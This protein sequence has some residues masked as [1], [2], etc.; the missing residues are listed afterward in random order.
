MNRKDR[1]RQ[2]SLTRHSGN[3]RSKKEEDIDQTRDAV[4]ETAKS[5]SAENQSTGKQQSRSLF[6]YTTGEGLIG[7]LSSQS[8]HATHAH[9]LNDLSEGRLILEILRPVLESELAEVTPTL[10]RLGLMR[11]DFMTHFGNSIYRREADNMLGAMTR[12]TDNVAPYFISS[13][14][15]HD[16]K[17]SA[18]QHGLLSQ[19][20]GYARGGFAI[21]FDEV[22]ID[23]LNSQEHKTF[24]YQGMF[25]D[26]VAYKDHADRVDTKNFAGF[27]SMML[28]NILKTN[29]EDAI[30]ILGNKTAV[31]YAPYFLSAA[32]F[33]KHPSFEEENEYRIVALCSRSNLAKSL[34][35][36]P[37]KPIKFRT[38]STGQVV[39]YI[40]F[41]E[42]MKTKLPIKGI[43]VGPQAEQENGRMAAEILL[44]QCGIT[45]PIR[46]SEIPFRT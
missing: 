5:P 45:A 31:D 25:T 12:A 13:F 7:I 1:R 17:D 46:M 26:T 32:P 24:S 18:Y 16:E 19:W 28:R 40:S 6:H 21:E 23:R 36:R 30:K 35:T 10:I 34:G 15:I 9:F 20:R 2:A 14:C 11:S 33:L 4:N 27:A 8:L 42:E 43:I 29:S 39:P 44:E 37:E 22:E 3:P 38:R 41:Y